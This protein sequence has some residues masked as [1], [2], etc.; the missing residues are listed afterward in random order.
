[1]QAGSP[2]PS[3]SETCNSRR[4]GCRVCFQENVECV[5]VDPQIREQEFG[6]FQDPGLT[7]KAGLGS[8]KCFL[9]QKGPLFFCA[10]RSGL[11]SKEWADSTTGLAGARP[12]S[13]RL[14][15]SKPTLQHCRIP[16]TGAPTPK[17]RPMFSTGSHS[18]GTSCSRT[19]E[20][21]C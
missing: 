9:H 20:K 6:N 19:M 11:R 10:V 8:Q 15:M 4:R 21:A 7:S 2:R 16:C 5:H 1:M 12:C 17:A 3:P 14:S 18:F 13:S